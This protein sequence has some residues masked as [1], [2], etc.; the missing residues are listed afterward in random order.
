M[1]PTV[2]VLDVNYLAYRA[3]HTTGGLKW[4]GQG[5]GVTYG[6]FR[7]V[8]GLQERFGASHVVFCFDHGRNK[9]KELLPDYKKKRGEKKQ[10]PEH[11]KAYASLEKEVKTLKEEYLPYLGYENVLYQDGY[12]ADDIIASWCKVNKGKCEIVVVTGDGDMLQVLDRGISIFNPT[13][14]KVETF[15]SF[16]KEWRI[17]P[18]AWAS[19]K[20]IAGCST[21]Q[22]P[23]VKGVGEKTAALFL[24]GELEGR[25]ARWNG[26]IH[27]WMDD[28]GYDKSLQLVKLPLQGC[29][30]PVLVKDSIDLKRWR[31]LT[32]RLGMSSLKDT[33]PGFGFKIK[34]TKLED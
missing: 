30:K 1:K 21:D 26:P 5:T 18:R 11:R 14:K 7:D 19:V 12:E 3:F 9:R 31:K 28:G 23:G 16:F 4:Q 24:R 13:S 17:E 33:R 29:I 10:S 6:L 8:V 15:D 32:T 2:L 22:V 25:Y 20:A 34:T 27:E